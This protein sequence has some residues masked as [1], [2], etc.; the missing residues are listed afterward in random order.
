MEENK[1]GMH[2]SLL[3]LEFFWEKEQARA[4]NELEPN[5]FSIEF[6]LFHL[7]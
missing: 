6:N 4:S 7:D 2:S 5:L 3:N 1:D